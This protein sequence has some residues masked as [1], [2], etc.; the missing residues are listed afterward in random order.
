MFLPISIPADGSIPFAYMLQ[1]YSLRAG[2]LHLAML[3]IL[4]THEMGHYLMCRYYKVPAT[5]PYLFARAIT[6]PVGNAWRIHYDARHPKKQARVIR[7]RRRRS[8][9][10][11]GRD[12][13]CLVFGIVRFPILAGWERPR[14]DIRFSRRQLPVLFICQICDVRKIAS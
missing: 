9:G 2:P 10:G 5:L 13:P 11:I 4:F 12:D 7:C 1:L 3:G 14:R 8:A 6:E